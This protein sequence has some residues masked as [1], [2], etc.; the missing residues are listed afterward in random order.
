LLEQIGPRERRALLALAI[1]GDRRRDP[2]RIDEAIREEVIESLPPDVLA[3]AVRELDTDDVV[4]IL[5]DLEPAAAGR[6]LTALEAA[7]RVAVEQ[8][9]AYPEYSAG[10]LM[11]R[12]VVW[13]P[14]TGRWARPS[15]ICARPTGCPTSSIT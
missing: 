13:R 2:V 4:D 11:Q 1:R 9:L 12:E 6:I 10:R 15:T 7:D 3:E 8:A 5:E 14:S